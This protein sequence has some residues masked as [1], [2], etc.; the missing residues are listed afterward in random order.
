MRI[1]TIP[2]AP[3]APSLA[4]ALLLLALCALPLRA[5]IIQ[6]AHYAPPGLPSGQGWTYSGGVLGEPDAFRLLG[7]V[8]VMDTRGHPGQVFAA[9]QHDLGSE[10]AATHATASIRCRLVDVEPE[11][12][13]AGLA[14]ALS[15]TRSAEPAISGM[16]LLAPG[17]LRLSGTTVAV[18]LDA[19]VWHE[20]TMVANLTAQTFA[21]LVDG[22]FVGTGVLSSLPVGSAVTFGDLIATG[23]G[24]AEISAVDAWVSDG[25]PVPVQ[26]WRW[27]AVK[28]LFAD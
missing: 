26:A 1:R 27:A 20:Y 18:P 28:A 24:R 23:N 4:T 7:G 3:S 22:A 2:T 21:V 6:E 17:E 14:L 16:V 11:A 9:Y 15:Y 10:P 25:G 13:S 12:D 19:T 5:D 8:L